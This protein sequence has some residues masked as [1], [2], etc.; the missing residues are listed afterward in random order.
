MVSLV[1]CVSEPCPPNNVETSVDCETGTGA[2]SWEMSVGAL[3]YIAF[4]NGRDGDSLSCHTLAHHTSCRVE[5]LNCGTVY[6]ARVRALG[7][8]LNSTDSTT[9]LLASGQ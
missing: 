2:I 7:D 4:F 5:G 3:G 6:Y 9:V 8:T 1:V